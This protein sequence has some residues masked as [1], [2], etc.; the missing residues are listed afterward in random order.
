MTLKLTTPSDTTIHIERVFEA[1]VAFV[2]RAFTEPEIVQQWLTGPP[3]HT[4]PIC[5]MDL[6]VGGKWRYVWSM[7]EGEMEAYGEYREIVVN[8][9]IVHTETFAQWP[10]TQTTVITNFSE[11]QGATTV[12]M[13]VEYPSKE[14]RDAMLQ[15]PMEQGMKACYRNLDDLAKANR[16]E[17][18]QD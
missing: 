13:T 2:W 10:D 15:T 7:P 4:M 17:T 9:K 14:V 8:E 3:G 1:P 5:E 18:R 16:A 11:Q 12:A 6:K